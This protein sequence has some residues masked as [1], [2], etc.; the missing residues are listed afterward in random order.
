MLRAAQRVAILRALEEGLGRLSIVGEV[1]TEPVR[2][3]V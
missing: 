1:L 3:L 2:R